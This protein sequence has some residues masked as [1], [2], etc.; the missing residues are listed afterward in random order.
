MFIV[1]KFFL[2]FLYSLYLNLHQEHQKKSESE[3]ESEIPR[4]WKPTWQ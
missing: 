2:P 4:M 1:N 3:S